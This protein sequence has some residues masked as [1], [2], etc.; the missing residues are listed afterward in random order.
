MRKI[1]QKIDF[2]WLEVVKTTSRWIFWP[3]PIFQK[4]RVFNLWDTFFSRAVLQAVEK[5]FFFEKLKIQYLSFHTH[6]QVVKNI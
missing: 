3:K 1:I 2:F 5:L 4:N 6:F